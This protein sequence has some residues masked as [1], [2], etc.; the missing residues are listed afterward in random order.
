MKYNTL[1]NILEKISKDAPADFVKYKLVKND[2]EKN[3]QIKAKCYIHLFLMVRFGIDDFRA[4]EK[5]ITEGPFDGGIDAYFL[6]ND[7]KTVFIIQSKYR[8]TADN[9]ENKEISIDEIVKMDIG[10]ILRGESK[11]ESGNEYNGKIKGFQREYNQLPELGLYKKKVIFLCNLLSY[12]E[13]IIKRLIDNFDFE[14]FNHDKTYNKLVFPL[15]TSTYFD[16]DSLDITINLDKKEIPHL[17]QE[18]NTEI[19]T[20]DITVVFVPTFEI[21]RVMS[22]YKNALLIFNPRNYLSLEKN[23]VN[24]EIRKSILEIETG[25]FALFNNG[26]T[27]FAD[28]GNVN[29]ATGRQMVGTVTIKK[30][31][32]INGGQTAFTLSKLFEDGLDKSKFDGK[33]VMLKIISPSYEKDASTDKKDIE[34]IKNISKSTNQQSKIEVADMRAN[35]DIQIEIQKTLFNKFGLLYERKKGEFEEAISKNL[36]DKKLLINRDDLMKAYLSFKGEPGQA[37]NLKK[38]L[39]FEERK[40][41]SII[42][43]IEIVDNLYLSV[44]LFQKLNELQKKKAKNFDQ[45]FK[46]TGYGLRY[47]INALIYMYNLVFNK[48]IEEEHVDANIEKLLEHWRKF[49]DSFYDSDDKNAKRIFDEYRNS[50]INSHIVEYSAEMKKNVS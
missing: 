14:V 4:R 17:R 30:P 34:I 32:I 47:G 3:N 7:S 29:T 31:Q 20:F 24:K 38:D 6:D 44:I 50:T 43:S 2:T 22:K 1:S 42:D 15:L 35:D 33:E 21:A 16:V 8:T 28:G 37:K 19:G 5:Y 10:R 49:E 45:D 40:F 36:V 18:I 9:F 11:D 26:I 48:Q 39:L 41:N 46:K 23:D 12:N 25:E 13:N 27:I